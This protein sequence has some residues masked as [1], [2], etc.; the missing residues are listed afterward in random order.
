MGSTREVV[1]NSMM[2]I[3]PLSTLPAREKPQHFLVLPTQ[4]ELISDNA[5]LGRACGLLVE[6]APAKL[7][8]F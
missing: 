3:I 4:R 6:G 2:S 1:A 8:E 5:S 7:P